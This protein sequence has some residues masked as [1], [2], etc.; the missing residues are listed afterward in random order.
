VG[1][2]LWLL[3]ACTG[4]ATSDSATQP[5]ET[6]PTWT[7]TDLSCQLTAH[8]WTGWASGL[9][10]HAQLRLVPALADGSWETHPMVV[11]DADPAGTWT[12]FALD[13]EADLSEV[14]PIPGRI[15]AHDCRREGSGWTW[16]LDLLDGD[17]VVACVTGTVA[18]TGVVPENVATCDVP[19]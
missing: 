4:T 1:T 5:T 12:L 7:Q 19:K 6:A 10:G 17:T 11:D 15:T 14:S 9:H 13:L 18:D 16:A 2:W 8:H 3:A